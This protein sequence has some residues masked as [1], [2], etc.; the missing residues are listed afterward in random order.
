VHANLGLARVPREPGTR[1]TV[2]HASAAVMQ[3]V[4]ERLILTADGEVDQDPDPSRRS[5]PGSL[6]G[7]LIW[8]ARP[9]LDLD[10]GYERSFGAQPVNRQWMAGL[11]YRFS[12]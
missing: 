4:D 3:Q 7:G 11:T 9:G 1:A 6:L 2:A 5:W 10:I 12:L 8:T